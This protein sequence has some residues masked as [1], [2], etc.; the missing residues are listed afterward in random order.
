MEKEEEDKTEAAVYPIPPFLREAFRR[1]VAACLDWLGGPEP[2]VK[3]G[4]NLVAISAVCRMAM[5]FRDPMP[6]ELL[7]IFRSRAG[8]S[9]DLLADPSYVAGARCLLSMIDLRKAQFQSNR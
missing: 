3:C 6:D 9:R 2:R 8:S 5:D 1:A 4:Q 7:E